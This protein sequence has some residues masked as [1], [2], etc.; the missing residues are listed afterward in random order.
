MLCFFN[1]EN[2]LSSTSPLQESLRAP[3]L[4]IV[5]TSLLLACQDLTHALSRKLSLTLRLVQGLSVRFL[6][7]LFFVALTM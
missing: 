2:F 6:W 5:W 1:L 3:A 7:T 4:L